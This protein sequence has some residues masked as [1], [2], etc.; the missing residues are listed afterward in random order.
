MVVAVLE[1]RLLCRCEPLRLQVGDKRRETQHHVLK[2]HGLVIEALVADVHLDRFAISE[3]RQRHGL[4]DNNDVD[5]L[6][7]KQRGV[8]FGRRR[9]IIH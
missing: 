1:C 5:P 8:V 6:R 7:A 4:V 9:R 3:R 2:Q